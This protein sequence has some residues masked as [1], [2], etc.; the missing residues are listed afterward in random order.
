MP[1]ETSPHLLLGAQDQQLGV[2]QDKLPCEPTG[3]SS[4]T[5]KR[6]KFVQFEHVLFH[7]SLS[8]TILQG[9]LEGGQ[10]CA[11]QSKCW[12]Y[13]IKEWR[14]LPVTELLTRVSCRKPGR[15]SLLNHLSCIP[16]PPPPPSN[17]VGKGTE[18][19]PSDWI[20]IYQYLW[21]TCIVRF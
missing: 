16:P 14:S 1:E 18:L 9:T 10:C 12:M 15:G 6:E 19:N 20:L 5:V 4:A 8:K 17:P 3:T 21:D 13:N 7:D 11:W 2:K